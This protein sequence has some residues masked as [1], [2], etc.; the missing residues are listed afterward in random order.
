MGYR[1]VPWPQ[2]L[3]NILDCATRQFVFPAPF[4]DHPGGF[5]ERCARTGLFGPVKRYYSSEDIATNDVSQPIVSKHSPYDAAWVISVRH[6]NM[7]GAGHRRF[8]VQA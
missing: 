3:P 2:V 7:L 6:S 8:H 1:F 5:A 4:L